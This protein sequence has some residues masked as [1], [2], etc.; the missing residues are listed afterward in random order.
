MAVFLSA[1]TAMY[2]Q[3]NDLLFVSE[4]S[5]IATAGQPFQVLGRVMNNTDEEVEGYAVSIEIGG[6]V[7]SNDFSTRTVVPGASADVTWTTDFV[8]ALPGDYPYTVTLTSQ[9]GVKSVES[10]TVHVR[11]RRWVVEERTGTW[12]AACV[13]GIYVFDQLDEKMGDG[14]IGIALH[15][16]GNDP[17]GVADYQLSSF[18]SDSSAPY[19]MINRT[20]GCHP[21]K[22]EGELEKMERRG[23]RASIEEASC[24]LNDAKTGVTVDTEVMFDAD[25]DAS[26]ADLRIGYFIIE[27]DVNVDSYEYSQKNGYSGQTTLP[28]WGEKP[29]VIPGK[30]MWFQHVGRGYS[31]DISGVS[32]SVPSE[33]KAGEIY[34]YSHSFT[35]PGNILNVDNCR[36]VIMAI[37]A[38]SN[39]VLNAVELPLDGSYSGLEDIVNFNDEDADATPR[40][41]GLNGMLVDSSNLQPGIYIELKGSKARKIVVR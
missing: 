18:T 29:A 7:Y 37:E 41:Y 40:Y 28:G 11:A 20:R 17:M 16:Y 14:F 1:A 33:V 38:K 2:A 10:S 30:D 15:T 13:A 24:R 26:S 35:L 4:I 21:L 5:A 8:P 22:L 31:E 19:C 9:G 39:S 34:R 25:Y 27:N 3:E 12:C 23:L 32:G 6:E 36:V